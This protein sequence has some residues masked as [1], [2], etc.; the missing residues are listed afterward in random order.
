MFQALQWL[1][2]IRRSSEVDGGLVVR[3]GE[4]DQ[5]L[6]LLDGAP[7]YYPWH[8][9][10]LLS[11]FQT[12]TFKDI[13]L[14]R[15]A[16]PAEH[17]G[18]LTGVL[19]A[20]MKDGRR[21]DPKAVAALGVLSGRFLVESPITKTSSFMV[22]AR[23]SYI[24]KLVGREH[25]VEDD[26]GRQDTLRTGYYF[27]DVSAKM[28][29]RPSLRHGLSFSYYRG[30]DDLDL[31]LPFDVSLDLSS[32]LRP[33][34]LFFEIG[35]NWG[36]RLYSARYQFLPSPRFFLTAT[37]YHSAYGA[38]EQTY[39]Q[40][41]GTSSVSSQYEVRLRDAGVKVD[42]DYYHSPAHRL[43]IG[44]QLAGHRFRSELDAEIERSADAVDTEAQRNR[45]TA[46]EG[47]VYVQD[48]WQPAPQWEVMPGLR[49]SYFN[50]YVH[51]NPRLSAQ[52]TVQPR[53]LFV[54]A[55]IGTQVQ[56]LHRLR[57]RYSFIYDLVSSRWIPSSPAVKP[58]QS[59]QG[60]LG[61]ESVPLPW[62]TLTADVYA[63]GARNVLVPEDIYRTKDGLEG[64]GIETGRALGPVRA[65]FGLG[66]RTGACGAGRAGPLVGV[67]QLRGGALAYPGVGP[68]RRALPARLLRR[69]PLAGR[70]GRASRPALELHTLGRSPERLCLLGPR[71]SLCPGRPALQRADALPP[72]P[73]DQQRTSA[74]VRPPRRYG[75]VPVR[76]GRCTVARRTAPVQPAQPPQRN[77]TQLRP[78]SGGGNGRGPA[79]LAYFAPAGARARIVS[80][81]GEKG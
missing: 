19:D 68:G 56:Y 11:T 5:N 73:R 63:R 34:D 16:F 38:R 57:D 10:S 55:G 27:Y 62:L 67:A 17:G 53:Q 45:I 30:R 15:G 74:R 7:V 36:N 65:G 22:S 42:V 81:L 26:E 54:R 39:I 76:V 1:P 41:S 61:V 46:L 31:R 77:R 80:A 13:K 33:T 37:A 79:R 32:W 78:R 35:H 21:P 4:P 24:D 2:G 59:L 29:Y 9:F 40:P 49:A 66:V 28:T 50:G 44:F 75:A 43:R 71:V 51:L 23:R 12:E 3:G 47:V 14:F 64:P 52:Y 69:A 25:P 6:F 8:A 48:T 58:S 20:E 70:R 72:P 60:D 18:R